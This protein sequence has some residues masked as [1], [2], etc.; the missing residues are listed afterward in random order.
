MA[1]N[2]KPPEGKNEL[3]AKKIVDS[4]NWKSDQDE[5]EYYYDDSHGYE[6]FDP[7]SEDDEEDDDMPEAEAEN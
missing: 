4:D 2:P 1:Q 5:R 3:P 7:D 6:K